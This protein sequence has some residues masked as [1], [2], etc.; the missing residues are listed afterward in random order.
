VFAPVIDEIAEAGEERGAGN[1]Q[2][3]VKVSLINEEPT[4]GK[5][6]L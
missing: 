4:Q 1:E 2:A 5:G 6:R 3:E